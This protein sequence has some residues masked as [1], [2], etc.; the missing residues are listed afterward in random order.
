MNTRDVAVDGVRDDNEPAGIGALTRPARHRRADVDA[1]QLLVGDLLKQLGRD[2]LLLTLPEHF[3]WMTAGG[4]PRGVLDPATSPVLYYTCDARWV[5]C[6]NT[7]SQ[8]LFDEEI[9]ELGFQIK[10]WPWHANRES[11]LAELC[12]G[13]KL[14]SDVPIGADVLNV[15]ARLATMRRVLTPYE[16]AALLTIGAV[17]SHAVEATCRTLQR[18]ETEREIAAQVAHRLMHRGILPV[19][20]GVAVDGRSRHY[21]RHG[22]TSTPLSSFATI[23]ATGRKYGLHATAARMVCLGQPSSDLRSEINAVARVTAGYVAA[24]WPDAFPREILQTGKRIYLLSGHEHEWLQ[25]PP[26]YVTGHCAVELPFQPHGDEL[27]QTGWPVV[28]QASAGAAMSADTF[29]VREEGALLITP[30]ENWPQKLVRIQGADVVRPDI[31]VREMH[32]IGTV[33]DDNSTGTGA[34]T[35]PARLRHAPTSPTEAQQ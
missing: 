35:R 16:Q 30:S 5:L 24:T 25:A 27:L 19:H 6:C 11:F 9:E 8:R 32:E 13:R 28:W 4:T 15:G 34:L 1:K 2:G 22:Y 20:V 7:D 12:A 14:A 23:T 33:G 17:V 10:E 31:L 29:L 26:G 18:N 3:S 21:R